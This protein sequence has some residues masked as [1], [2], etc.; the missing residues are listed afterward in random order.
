VP[1]SVPDSLLLEKVWVWTW[2]TGDRRV[3]ILYAA[4]GDALDA[5][6]KSLDVRLEV[7][8]WGT[9]YRET[10][11]LRIAAERVER[12]EVG[13]TAEAPTSENQP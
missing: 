9:L 7:R 13:T 5:S 10:A 8:I 6:R 12:I 2:A 3:R 4:P 1:S 11:G